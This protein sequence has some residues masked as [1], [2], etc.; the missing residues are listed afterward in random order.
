MT[1]SSGYL[2]R[3]IVIAEAGVNH[4]GNIKLAYKLIDMA[5]RCGADYVKFQTSTPHLHISQ[6]AEKANIRLRMLGEN[7]PN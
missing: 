6:H 2:K 1:S 3:T 7:K 5:K 4:N